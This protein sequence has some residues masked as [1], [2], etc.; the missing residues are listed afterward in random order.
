[1]VNTEK[2]VKRAMEVLDDRQAQDLIRIPIR[3]K[4]SLADD[5]IVCHGGSTVQVKAL[6][7]EV[8]YQLEKDFGLEPLSVEGL[9]N[10]H[11]VLL[12]YGDFIVHI[13]TKQARNYYAL[14]K[15]WLSQEDLDALNARPD[16]NA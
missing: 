16:K 6:A 1:M 7:D 2:F 3:E 9:E 11:W 8:I 13:F 14:E 10:L 12:D 5:F 4:S 15:L